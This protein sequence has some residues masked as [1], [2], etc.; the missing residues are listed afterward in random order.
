MSNRQAR[1]ARKQA[2]QNGDKDQQWYKDPKRPTGTYTS[3]QDK[4]KLRAAVRKLLRGETV[5][6]DD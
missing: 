2:V 4:Q 6:S 5:P 3:K 1:R